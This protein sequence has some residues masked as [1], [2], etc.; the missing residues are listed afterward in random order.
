M[1]P[2]SIS[3]V[4]LSLSQ[5]LICLPHVTVI[6]HTPQS[7]KERRRSP[8]A[9][10]KTATKLKWLY[11]RHPRQA[12]QRLSMAR[13]ATGTATEIQTQ[14]NSNPVLTSASQTQPTTRLACSNGHECCR[15]L[16]AYSSNCLISQGWLASIAEG[17]SIMNTTL[18]NNNTEVLF[19]TMP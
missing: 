8:V 5:A 6:M 16:I 4:P 11:A 3:S 10:R 1:S 19:S 12:S 9:R 7:L 2:S 18:L 15:L 13:Y 14:R 17:D